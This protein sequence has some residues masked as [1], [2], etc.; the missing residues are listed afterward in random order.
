MADWVFQAD[1][2][3]DDEV[4][5]GPERWWN[6]PQHRDEISIGDRV[7]LQ[8]TGRRDPGVYYLAT[9]IRPV[10]ESHEQVV[11][12]KPSFGRWRTDIRFQ[13]RIAPPLLRMDL[14]ED[15]E[16]ASFYPFRGFQGSNRPMSIEI[17]AKLLEIAALVPLP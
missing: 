3:I 1:H 12:E 10:Y 17:S 11:P 4:A 2:P 13:Y 8:V 7:W 15:P 14:I 5:Q 6:T 16:L 9:V